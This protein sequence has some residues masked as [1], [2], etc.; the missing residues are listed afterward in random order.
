MTDDFVVEFKD[1]EENENKV[2]KGAVKLHDFRNTLDGVDRWAE[3]YKVQEGYNVTFFKNNVW[4]GTR[5]IW[6]H[7]EQYA[8]DCAENFVM[9]IFD[10]GSKVQ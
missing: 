1:K 7:S 10:V 2:M 4:Y 5:N 9:S 6:D 3:V 8:E